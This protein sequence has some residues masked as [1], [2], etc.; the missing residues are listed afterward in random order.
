M[1]TLP[2][3]VRNS[4]LL[5]LGTVASKGL[6]LVAYLLLTRALG[7][8]DFGRYAL[9]FA[10]L[11]FFE[12]I[13]DCGLDTLSVRQMA[14][15]GVR[16]DT[17]QRLGD[18]L[19]LR[20]L[21]IALAVPGA[22]LA[23]PLVTGQSGD[24]PLVLL[25]GLTLVASNRRP[26]LRSLFEVPFRADLRMGLPTLLGVLTEVLHLLLLLWLLSTWGLA[27]AVGAQGLAPLPFLFVLAMFSMRRI[28]PRM[29]PNSRRLGALL[30]KAAP[31]LGIL[32]LNVLLQRLD[33]LML[34]RMRD[35]VEVGLYAAPVRIVEVLN[36][37]PIL[38]MTSVYPLF[39]RYAAEPLM[40]DRLFR[41]S[42]RVLVVVVIPVVALEIAF[43][44]P[45]IRLLLGEAYAPS[46]EVLPWLA[47]A[48]I[49]I[50]ADIVIGAR[51]VAT[52]HERR[53]LQLVLFA[54][55]TNLGVNLW[56]IPL[57][58]ARGAAVAT[59]AAF[60]V[61]VL[62]G[63]LFSDTRALTV[64][65]VRSLLPAAI[66][67]LVCF[68]PAILLGDLRLAAFTFGV[69]AYPVAL[70]VLGA[71]RPAEV[72]RLIAAFRESGRTHTGRGE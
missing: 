44:A 47:L 63:V 54:M 20:L 69:V 17:A 35:S 60:S 4:T 49:G 39:S 30:L 10:Y 71:V 5:A 57:L 62:A 72:T 28:R 36:L 14:R 2:A 7:P 13:A 23:F 15:D 48:E 34:E 33:V 11:A 3:L 8:E 42:L 70:Y 67:G 19:L 38:L 65:A 58:G 22:A 21:L 1:S 66:A 46:A 50:Y 55:L 26:S 37:L 52:R 32:L 41:A 56:L 12:L 9:I 53:N 6:V 68:G 16:G 59:L 43:A 29:Q 64:L 24:A 61:R 40:L 45:I 25:A 18:S 51:L 31:L 27:G